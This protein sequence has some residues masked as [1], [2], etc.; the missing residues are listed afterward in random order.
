MV[1]LPMAST[2]AMPTSDASRAGPVHLCCTWRLQREALGS[3][4]MDV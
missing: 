1:V 4:T 2:V 3:R